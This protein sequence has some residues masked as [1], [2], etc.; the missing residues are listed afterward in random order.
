MVPR[1]LESKVS[2]EARTSRESSKAAAM[3]GR[4]CSG[5]CGQPAGKLECPKCQMCVAASFRY[6]FH[7]FGLSDGQLSLNTS[8]TR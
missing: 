5:G 8:S 4:L 6:F 3:G 7:L 1:T 2:G